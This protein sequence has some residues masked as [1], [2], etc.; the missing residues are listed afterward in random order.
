[1]RGKSVCDSGD[2]QII[3]RWLPDL[4]QFIQR[5]PAAQVCMLGAGGGG[6]NTVAAHFLPKLHELAGTHACVWLHYHNADMLNVI[7][8]SLPADMLRFPVQVLWLAYVCMCV[9][10]CVSPPCGGHRATPFAFLAAPLWQPSAHL[11]SRR[12]ISSSRC[13]KAAS[14][15]Q[16]SVARREIALGRSRHDGVA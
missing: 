4:S 1:M 7:P 13:T 6:Y 5:S 9:C 8:P 16:C 2:S 14:A 3:P 11:F 10:V 15:P 12:D